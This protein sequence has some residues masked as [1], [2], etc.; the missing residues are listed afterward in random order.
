M[1]SSFEICLTNELGNSSFSPW[2]VHIKHLENC[3]YFRLREKVGKRNRCL[4]GQFKR[5]VIYHSSGALKFS[6]K[7][8]FLLQLFHLKRETEPVFE[9]VRYKK[10]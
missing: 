5:D 3:I 7:L 8:V 10:V 1:I 6:I 4:L 2:D 9:T